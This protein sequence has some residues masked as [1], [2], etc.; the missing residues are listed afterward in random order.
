[1][2]SDDMQGSSA[3]NQRRQTS[4]S[5]AALRALF[6]RRRPGVDQCPHC[7]GALPKVRVDVCKHCGRDLIW[8]GDVVGKSGQDEWIRKE[9]NHKQ[10][11]RR[12]EKERVEKQKQKTVEHAR[13]WIWHYGILLVLSSFYVIS[14]SKNPSMWGNTVFDMPLVLCFALGGIW[15]LYNVVIFFRAKFAP[16]VPPPE[17]PDASPP[18]RRYV[19]PPPHPDVLPPPLP[20]SSS[21]ST[22][23]C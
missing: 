23:N 5:I 15:S 7:G 6:P 18:P 3:R 21:R 11:E 16:A 10:R 13:K 2:S 14:V 12:L 9:Y 20:D 8:C 19:S 4:Q 1:M 17:D 22:R